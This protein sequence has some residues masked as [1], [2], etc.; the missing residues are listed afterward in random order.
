VIASPRSDLLAGYRSSSPYHLCAVGACSQTLHT[1]A[2]LVRA[3]SKPD[4]V[5]IGA[6]AAGIAAALALH[7]KGI[8]VVV[9][10][11]RE[12]IGGR[13]WTHR[14]RLTPVPIELGAEFIHGRAEVLEEI[15]QEAQLA[16][17]DVAGGRWIATRRQ[18]RR[19]DDFWEQ[20]HR[21]M[22]PLGHPSTRDRSFHDFLESRSGGTRLAR[23][24]RLTRQFVEGF[25]AAEPRLISTQ[26]LVDGG[27]P[28]AD[29]RETRLARVIDGYDRLIEWMAAPIAGCIRVGAVVT[30]VRWMRANVA[31]EVRHFAGQAGFGVEAR[32]AIVTIPLGVLQARP[33]EIGAVEFDPDLGQAKRKALD[34]LESGSAVRVVVHLHDRIWASQEFGR[35]MHS[36]ELDA[37]GFLH[38]ND[39]DFP[40]W[41]TVYPVRAPVI[42]GWRGG[43]GARRLSQLPPG[44]IEARAIAS[45][46]RHLRIAPQRLRSMVE[47]V[48][49]HDW[50]HD[51]FARGAYSYQRVGGADAPAALARPLKRTLFFAG[52]ATGTDG[53]TGT[54]DAAIVTGRRAAA[55]VLRALIDK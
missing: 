18:I 25:H 20:L 47:H 32:A 2:N 23:E 19:L 36:Q 45:L 42:I 3:S 50:E 51:P 41:W 53:G 17:I 1:C 34:L 16:R 6:G 15:L 33:N 11:A 37:L 10:E 27:I 31:V 38:S 49:T 9:L 48:W 30:R 8:G 46:A 39:Q 4:V 22:R 43:P 12:R 55:Q 7:A 54:V 29:I 26:A 52:E 21:V 5:V 24:R 13:V 44:Q 28:G 40:L 14:D 35:K